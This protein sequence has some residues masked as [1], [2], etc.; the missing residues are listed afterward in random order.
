MFGRKKSASTRA[1]EKADKAAEKAQ[2]KATRAADKAAKKGTGKATA[3]AKRADRKA[4]KAAAKIA[5][6]SLFD[7]VTD[8]KSA[9]RA[10][11][12]AKIVGPALAPFALKAATS[13]RDYLDNRKA[14]KLGVSP[15]EVGA[16][17]GPT[18]TTE[19]RLKGLKG[20]IAELRARRTGDLQVTRFS[21]VA[22]TRIADL[23]TAVR[24]AITMPAGRR[25]V[26][27]SAVN[28]ELDQ[29]D[30]DLMT[31]LVTR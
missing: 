19:A 2:K 13:T 22:A 31:F 27:L 10:M 25:R 9:R 3:V 17:R 21:D 7:R 14:A 16:F 28:K 12:A 4:A 11:S 26:T 18:G 30:A 15:E 24:A 20:S 5:P 1:A 29:I 6:K 8:P 23:T